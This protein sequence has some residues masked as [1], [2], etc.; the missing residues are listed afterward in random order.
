M[1]DD[2]WRSV[3]CSRGKYSNVQPYRTS[4]GANDTS[5]YGM[6]VIFLARTKNMQKNNREQ[7][8][9]SDGI[10]GVFF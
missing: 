7:M 3:N 4:H 8:M 9:Y 1:T 10:I 2:A 5:I 6:A